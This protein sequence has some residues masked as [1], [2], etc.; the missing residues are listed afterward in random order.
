MI[1]RYPKNVPG[2]FYVE[3][4]C[5]MSCG[6]PESEAGDMF[7]WDELETYVHCYVRRQPETPSDT[8]KMLNVVW[9]AEVECIRYAGSDP[10]II[11]RLVQSGEGSVCDDNL[12]HQYRAE[13]RDE[14]LFVRDNATPGTLAAEFH[15]YLFGIPG[16]DERPRYAVRM[17]AASERE[18]IIRLSWFAPHFHRL[19]FRRGSTES[20]WRVQIEP[21]I[22]EAGRAVCR[23]LQGW[24]DSNANIRDQRWSSRAERMAGIAQPFAY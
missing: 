2:D 10:E 6:V 1:K 8:E 11:R 13:A 19:R 4:G 14:V 22:K 12:R 24:L 17:G 20:E 9:N 23:I 16:F 15:A 18:A 5:C 3:D 21:E 7:E